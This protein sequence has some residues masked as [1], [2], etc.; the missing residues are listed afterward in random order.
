[1]IISTKFEVDATIRQL[2]IAFCCWYVTWPCDLDLWPLILDSGR[3]S[4]VMWSTPSPNLQILGL[5]IRSWVM[6]YDVSH[7]PS[8]TMRL[9]QRPCNIISPYLWFI[10]L[11]FAATA[12]AP[13]WPVCRVVTKTTTY[14][15]SPIPPSYSLRVPS[16]HAESINGS[17]QLRFI[18][19]GGFSV[20]KTSPVLGKILA[21]R[22][23]RWAEY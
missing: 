12:H 22:G 4:R 16:Y 8:L 19:L 10:F 5:C 20:E 3:T 6:S 7:L 2:V 23:G 15:E 13:P 18:P 17:L 1:M 11:W 21:F 14:L 9:Q